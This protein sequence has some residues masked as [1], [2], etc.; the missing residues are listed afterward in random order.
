M[1]RRAEH[2]SGTDHHHAGD[3]RL[4]ED[5]EDDGLVVVDGARRVRLIDHRARALLGELVAVGDTPPPVFLAAGVI[6]LHG[7]EHGSAQAVELR[8]QR[9]RVDGGEGWTIAV[10]DVTERRSPEDEA[11]ELLSAVCHEM[12]TPIA[13]IVGYTDALQQGWGD[14]DAER[15]EAFLGVISRQGQRLTRLVDDLVALSRPGR[16]LEVRPEAVDVAP[17]VAEVLALLGPDVDGIEL[18]ADPGVTVRV[19]P[20]H[21]QNIVTNLVTN[22]RKYGRPPVVVEVVRDGRQGRIL[23]RDAGPG[24]P[25]GFV[26]RMWDR[27]SRARVEDGAAATGSGLGLAVVASLTAANGG[28]VAYEPCEPTG[29]CFTVSLPLVLEV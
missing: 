21:L 15:R 1:L 17:S 18:R 22:A 6:T 2:R 14:L 8:V 25:D 23:V 5:R 20:Y 29:A 26:E 4:F 9:S 16:G 7:L 13:G 28:R 27:F 10:A 11:A 19:D 24:V 12:R 3:D